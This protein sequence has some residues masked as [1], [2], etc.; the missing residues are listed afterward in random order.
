MR[1]FVGILVVLFEVITYWV[2]DEVG[3]A[4]DLSERIEVYYPWFY[5][6]Y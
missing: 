6:A 1:E 5:L 4:I 3:Y 2:I